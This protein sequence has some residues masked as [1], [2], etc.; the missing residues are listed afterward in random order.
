MPGQ[1]GQSF[2]FCPVC[3]SPLESRALKTG[4]P[5]RLVC[6]SNACG[7]VFYLDPK[8]A[9]GTIVRLPDGR[10]VLARRA[11]E[12]GF[13][14][15]VFPGGYVDRG[16]EVRTAAVREAREEAGI[17][18]R[19]DGLVGIYSYPGTTAVIIVYLATWTSGELVIDDES[20]EIRA[21]G[22][23]ELPWDDLAF[24]STRDALRDYLRRGA[25]A[26][27]IEVSEA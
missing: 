1:H 27:G 3:G 18:I 26:A 19:L 25:D 8:L 17:E 24:S 11:I 20:S 5:M 2:R 14:Q 12:P 22:A 7:Y 16:E 10:I 23:A 13:G 21:F 4:E 9:V 6:A 15:W